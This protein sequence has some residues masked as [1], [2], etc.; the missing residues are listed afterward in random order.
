MISSARTRRGH[1]APHWP[2]LATGKQF[3]GLN[4]LTYVGYSLQAG[5][6]AAAII[7][8]IFKVDTASTPSAYSIVVNGDGTFEI[9]SG[10]DTSRQS[11]QYDIFDLQTE[12]FYGV[13]TAW[14]NERAPIWARGLVL[15][16]LPL[17]VEI[18]PINLA[19][20]TYATSPS[21][22]VL[23]FSVAVGVLPPGISLNSA[24]LLS[25][26]PT[27]VGSFGF[28]VNATDYTLTS[29]VSPTCFISVISA[30]PVIVPSFLGMS[31]AQGETLAASVNLQLANGGGSFDPTYAS[32]LINGQ[33]PAANTTVAYNSTVTV[34]YSLGTVPGDF[35]IWPS[36]IS[37]Y[38]NSP[39]IDA[40]INAFGQYFDQSTNFEMFYNYIWNVDTAQGFGLAI[41]GRIVGV[42]NLLTIPAAVS[43]FGFFDSTS[44]PD[45]EPFNQASFYSG[46][47]ATQTYI[48]P[49][50]QYRQLVLMKAFANISATTAPVLNQMLLTLFGSSGRCYCMDLGGMQMMFQFEFFLSPVQYAILTQSG[51]V[52]RPA[53]VNLIIQQF[54]PALTFG[55]FGGTGVPF[56]QGTFY[57]G[58]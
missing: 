31:E 49:D 34:T 53:G 6:S 29:S 37:Q 56:N 44:P 41:L 21:G 12:A 10:G 38:A 9:Y 35:D 39:T 13:G 43:N 52:P 55:F 54:A 20:S 24:G 3:V 11:F 42:S 1:G 2:A 33:A 45:Y 27:A 36:V 23:I 50:D 26:T 28:T 7:G 30:V 16:N 4:S 19:S 57:F 47:Q 22:D 17:G 8:D 25:G 15:S 46:A 32:D 48:L 58:V 51:V 5:A 14:I 40:L 18:A